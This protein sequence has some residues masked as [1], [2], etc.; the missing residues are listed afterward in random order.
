[1]NFSTLLELE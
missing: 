1:M